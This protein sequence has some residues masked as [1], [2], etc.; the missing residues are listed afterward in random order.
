M[1]KGNIKIS[2]KGEACEKIIF[3][4]SMVKRMASQPVK[5]LVTSLLLIK[6]KSHRPGCILRPHAK[7]KKANKKADNI[8][9]PVPRKCVPIE[10]LVGTSLWW[11]PEVASMWSQ[12]LD[13]RWQT[14]GYQVV[15]F[16]V[17]EMQKR[18][19][20]QTMFV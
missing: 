18:T 12:F 17:P 2:E 11:Y 9:T 7:H 3:H 20:V 1:E 4:L 16:Q 10:A 19:N 6:E 15:D 5:G 13:T 14:F 8:G